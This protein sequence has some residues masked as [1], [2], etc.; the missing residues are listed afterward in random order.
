MNSANSDKA[1]SQ[2]LV[3]LFKNHIKYESDVVNFCDNTSYCSDTNIKGAKVAGGA[4]IGFSKY[5]SIKDCPAYYMPGVQ[6]QLS[7]PKS[8]TNGASVTKKCWG[9]LY[10]DVNGIKGPDTIGQDVFVYG[11]GEYGIEK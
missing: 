7:A 3:N 5:D 1:T 11:L 9:E 10:M 2:D 8:F 4:Y 6:G